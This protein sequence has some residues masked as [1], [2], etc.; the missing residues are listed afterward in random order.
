MLPPRR[1]LGAG[2]APIVAATL[3]M[4]DLRLGPAEMGAPRDANSSSRAMSSS[5]WRGILH[6]TEPRIEHHVVR[7]EAA[8]RRAVTGRLP[9]SSHVFDDVAVSTARCVGEPAHLGHR[10]A[11][12]HQNQ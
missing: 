12:V 3:A 10:T 8:L 2:S 6:E 11:R 1:S 9:L 5:E 4:N 7:R